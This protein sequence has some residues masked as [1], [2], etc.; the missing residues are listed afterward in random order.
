MTP[1]LSAETAELPKVQI[2]HRKLAPF[3]E[4]EIVYPEQILM[5]LGQGNLSI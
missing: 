5:L 3:L 1:P 4:R 2:V